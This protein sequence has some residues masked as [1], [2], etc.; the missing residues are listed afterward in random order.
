MTPEQE[1]Q[2][3]K[4]EKLRDAP[5]EGGGGSGRD[6]SIIIDL[7]DD[8]AVQRALKLGVLER[9]DLDEFD[10]PGGEG[11]ED[12][13]GGKGGK[14]GE[15]EGGEGG[16]GEGNPRRRLSIADRALGAE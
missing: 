11:G 14:G 6:L 13:K 7:G 8:K 15:G 3:A 10:A 9:G 2:L 4:L 5:E 12:G 1:E 16:E